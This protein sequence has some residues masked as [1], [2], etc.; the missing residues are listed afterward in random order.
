[1]APFG[2]AF[3]VACRRAGLS[4]WDAL[5]FSTLVFTGSAQ[6]AAV[7]V[8]D[9]G[10]SAAAAVVAGLLLNLRS[11]AFGI[12]L[13]P[14]LDG[15][16]WKRALWSQ[17]MIDESAAVASAQPDRRRQRTGYLVTG[18]GVFVAW[19]AATVLGASILSGTGSLVTTLGIDATIPAAF[20]A[21]LWPRLGDARTRGA[22]ALGGLIAFLL[23][24][25]APAGIPVVAAG[26]AAV[27]VRPTVRRAGGADR[28]DGP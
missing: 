24:P 12:S 13:A 14:A 23:V 11:L 19:N 17:L 22:A 15:P 6:F 1:V 18:I 25:V 2:V 21:L 9:D 16:R 20:L 27:A 10:G 4:S 5:G 8:L 28:A 26:V 3:G 7:S